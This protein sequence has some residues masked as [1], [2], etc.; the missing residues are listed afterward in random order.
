[1]K[2]CYVFAIGGTGARILESLTIQLAAGC[3]YE[4]L[5][6][7]EIVPIIID[8]DADNGNTSTTRQLLSNYTT[9]HEK[10]KGS[11][12]NSDFFKVPLKKL[13]DVSEGASS[14]TFTMSVDLTNKAS[15]KQIIDYEALSV[16]QDLVATGNLVDLLFSKR[17]LEMTLQHGFKGRPNIGSVVFS[18]LGQKERQNGKLISKNKD[19]GAFA[20]SFKDGDRVF[21]IGSIF[22]GTGAAGI[23]WLI[24]EIRNYHEVDVLSKTKIGLL[25]VMPYFSISKNAKS[26]IDSRAF[27]TRTK[28]A[29]RYYDTN[30][31]EAN[32]IFYL[33]DG[34]DNLEHSNVEG[35][36]GQKN[37][38]HFVE[39]LGA[40]SLIKFLSLED[41][42]LSESQLS[43]RYGLPDLNGSQQVYLGN[44]KS[45]M[46]S[47]EWINRPLT[48]FYLSHLLLLKVFKKTR[49][50]NWKLNTE[51]IEIVKKGFLSKKEYSQ[52][53]FEQGFYKAL[54]EFMGHFNTYF[55]ELGSGNNASHLVF[56][57]FM[58][59]PNV[60]NENLDDKSSTPVNHILLANN[61]AGGT[62]DI[63]SIRTV[64]KTTYYTLSDKRIKWN[65]LV[66]IAN[67]LVTK[68]NRLTHE[69]A[70]VKKAI[71]L[72]ELLFETSEQFL[73]KYDV[74]VVN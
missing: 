14:E 67:A 9:V 63:E 56:T 4:I 70:E 74:A 62:D 61:L 2:K 18:Q 50:I 59:N 34:N 3:G 55:S 72:S 51:L 58:T 24:K 13:K 11:K 65:E 39:F 8:L 12:G 15:L 66:S 60:G 44:F 27:I 7:W 1:M 10:L 31:T 52:T 46:A 25:S 47:R 29:L 33:A 37:K 73:K 57:P 43:F 35:G 48:R 20:H 38:P 32:A 16:S 19:F 23:P 26:A 36:N 30:L 21:V 71:R 17:D 45:N 42:R 22:G 49:S 54:E 40:T 68:V 53:F 69:Q 28:S 41:K 5:K 64:G 6:N